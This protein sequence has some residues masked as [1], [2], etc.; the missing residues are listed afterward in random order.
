M[1][2]SMTL[3]PVTGM[4]SHGLRA[5]ATAARAERSDCCTIPWLLY[6]SEIAPEPA[7]S[8]PLLPPIQPTGPSPQSGT[9]SVS[10]SRSA[11][12]CATAPM[13]M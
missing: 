8:R 7:E 4:P 9:A 10:P 5:M 1:A 6:F 13:A 12:L 11:D 3:I 2:C